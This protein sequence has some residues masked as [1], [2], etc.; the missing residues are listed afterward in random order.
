MEN[1]SRND[2]KGGPKFLIDIDPKRDYKYLLDFEVRDCVSRQSPELRIGAEYSDKGLEELLSLSEAYIKRQILP[3]LGEKFEVVKKMITPERRD[4]PQYEWPSMFKRAFRPNF[5]SDRGQGLE[6]GFVDVIAEFLGAIEI[7]L[8][9]ERVKAKQRREILI[10]FLDMVD[11][12]MQIPIDR[13]I[14]RFA[15]DF[16]FTGARVCSALVVKSLV[17][18]RE[19][20]S[21]K[22]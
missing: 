10:T 7:N 12:D 5:L 13:N 9:N 11:K 22:N 19:T 4:Y 6:L 21:K 8:C 15:D 2:T 3:Q 16:A 14:L 18:R 17:P 20:F 1:E